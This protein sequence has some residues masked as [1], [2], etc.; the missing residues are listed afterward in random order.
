MVPF[1]GK[2]L[3]DAFN[4]VHELIK[5]VRF[6]ARTLPMPSV[7]EREHA[8]FITQGTVRFEVRSVITCAL[9]VERVYLRMGVERWLYPFHDRHGV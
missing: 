5:C 8:P 4:V 3:S 9:L 2:M 7:V 6:G 1:P